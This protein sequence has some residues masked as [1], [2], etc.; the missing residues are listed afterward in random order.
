MEPAEVVLRFLESV[1]RKSE[2]EFYLSLFRAEPKEQFAAI[3]VDSNVARYATEAVVLHVRFLVSL[4]LVPVLAFGA[5]GPADDS[6]HVAR[7]RRRLE[8]AG[9]PAELI[10]PNGEPPVDTVRQ[11]CRQGTIPIL[12]YGAAHG[13]TLDERFT[14]LSKLLVGL[15]TRKLIFLHRPGGLRQAG[16]LLPIVNVVSDYADL[17]LSKDLSRKEKA[18]LAQSRRLL[19][20]LV[21]H[22]MT[23]A[24][25]SPLNLFRELFTLKGAGTLLRRGAVIQRRRGFGDLD[26]AKLGALIESA[27]GRAPTAEFFERGAS[28]VYLEENYRGAAV[29]VDAPLGAYLTKFAVERQAQGEGLGRDL[30]EAMCA[31]HPAVLWRARVRNPVVEWYTKQADGLVRMGEW[32]VFWRGVSTEKIPEVVRYCLEQPVDLAASG[33]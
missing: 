2:A 24:V 30:W 4:G 7:I 14:S 1:G 8:K 16:G 18:I 26:A 15:A 19:T 22:R 28:Q 13:A 32:V 5:F 25:T 23:I 11:A 27:F 12:A 3:S 17:A 33:S 31:E 9:A 10:S 29:L 6:E 21:P 20:D